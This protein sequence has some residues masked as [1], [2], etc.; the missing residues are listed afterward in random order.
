[1]ADIVEGLYIVEMMGSAVNGITG[2]YSRGATGFMIR[3]GALAEPVAE[4]TVAGNLLGHAGRADPGLRPGVPARHRCAD[5][6]D[7]RHDRRRR[8]EHHAFRWHH[9]SA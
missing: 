8:L 7:R 4:I 9:L 3:N 1:M 2:D 6:P 5:H